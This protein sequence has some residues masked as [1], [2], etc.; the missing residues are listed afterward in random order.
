MRWIIGSGKD[1]AVDDNQILARSKFIQCV[2]GVEV[3]DWN[4]IQVNGQV[5]K[6]FLCCMSDD[7][8]D[9]TFIT[10][11]I[12]GV[13]KLCSLREVRL[14]EFVV[15]NTCIW[16]RM[17]HKKLLYSMMKANLGI[18]LWFAKQELS[19]GGDRTFRQTTTLLNI[20][21]FGFQT[22]LS[23]RNLFKNRNRGLMEAIRESFIRVSPILCLG[24]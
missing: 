4:Y 7:K 8:V 14:G 21:Q 10:A 16:E 12:H 6:E 22:S 2:T 18:E 3:S 9:G 20:G 17:I 13:I 5:S 11:H 24:D 23:E 19:I 1:I 15:A